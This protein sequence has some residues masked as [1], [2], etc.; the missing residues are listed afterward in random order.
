LVD[1]AASHAGFA[2]MTQDTAAAERSAHVTRG[3]AT[4]DAPGILVEVAPGRFQLRAVAELRAALAEIIERAD[5]GAPARA[6]A[7]IARRTLGRDDPA[8]PTPDLYA[9]GYRAGLAAAATEARRQA[10][11]IRKRAMGCPVTF[12]NAATLEQMADTLAEMPMV[13]E[14]TGLEYRG[15]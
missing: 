13:R 3:P 5:A 2:A 4:H 1:A 6:L 8:A 7:S 15:G 12:G 10:R 14:A 9:E 11:A